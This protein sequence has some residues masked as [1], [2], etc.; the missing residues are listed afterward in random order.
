M[1]SVA[2]IAVILLLVLSQNA[3]S[4]TEVREFSRFR[5]LLRS[6]ERFEGRDGRLTET[7]L[8]G[9]SSKGEAI[10]ISMSNLRAL[11]A[12]TGSEAGKWALAG[13]GLGLASGLLAIMQV[14]LNDDLEVDSDAAL[15]VTAGLTAVGALIGGMVG[16]SHQKWERV[17]IRTESMSSIHSRPRICFVRISF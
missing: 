11:D 6:G 14:N 2:R 3:F 8:E 7:G 16:A 4:Q 12:A 15:V 9:T 1:T 17:P 13:A 5:V 10:K